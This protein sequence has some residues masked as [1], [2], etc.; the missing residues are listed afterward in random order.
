[1]TSFS[2]AEASFLYEQQ[3]LMQIPRC[4]SKCIPFVHTYLVLSLSLSLPLS[5]S[6]SNSP[7]FLYTSFHCIFSSSLVRIYITGTAGTRWSILLAAA[8]FRSPWANFI[9]NCASFNSIFFCISLWVLQLF[10]LPRFSFLFFSSCE[11]DL[12]Q[13]RILQWWVRARMEGAWGFFSLAP[14][15]SPWWPKRSSCIWALGR[16]SPLRA[17]HPMRPSLDT[18]LPWVSCKSVN[19]GLSRHFFILGKA[20]TGGK[21]SL[22]LAVCLNLPCWCP[23]YH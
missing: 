19:G 16:P 5:P 4:V 1:M 17:P 12:T 8:L 18:R 11:K 9:H 20:P 14:S 3:A 2:T 13:Y 23:S 21:L 6:L 7:S 15:A 10:P 22:A